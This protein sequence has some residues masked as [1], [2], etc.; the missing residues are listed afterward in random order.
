MDVSSHEGAAFKS[1][2]SELMREGWTES[3]AMATLL[4]LLGS[5]LLG[6]LVQG[7]QETLTQKTGQQENIS[8]ICGF[9]GEYVHCVFQFHPH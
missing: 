1:R 4:P 6:T 3:L 5:L 7:V 8:H 9:S 2:K